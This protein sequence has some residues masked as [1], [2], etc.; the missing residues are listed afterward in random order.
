VARLQPTTSETWK[1]LKGVKKPIKKMSRD[2]PFGNL[3]FKK[4][5]DNGQ[6]SDQNVVVYLETNNLVP[7]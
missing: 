7:W 5:G 1:T 6:E 4:K 3:T 2:V